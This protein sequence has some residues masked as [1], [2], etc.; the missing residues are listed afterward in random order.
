MIHKLKLAGLG[1]ADAVETGDKSYEIRK[2]DRDFHVGDMLYQIL[3]YKERDSYVCH[4]VS[5]YLYVV[6]FVSKI[7]IDGE[8]Y[9]V[10]AIKKGCSSKYVV[11]ALIEKFLNSGELCSI[12]AYGNTIDDCIIKS[13]DGAA[14][15]FSSNGEDHIILMQD[16]VWIIPNLEYCT[17]NMSIKYEDIKF[18]DVVDEYDFENNHLY[19]LFRD[20]LHHE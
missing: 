5:D 10:L 19:Y 13:I 3:Y 16:V 2:A 15:K 20:R 9:D 17:E 14:F 18:G 7:S 6:T 4:N 1:L 11:R 8:P 12:M